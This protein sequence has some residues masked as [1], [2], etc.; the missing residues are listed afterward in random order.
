MKSI[1]QLLTTAFALVTV[2]SLG[3]QVL[4]NYGFDATSTVWNPTTV[5]TNVSA[6]D[7]TPGP[8][9]TAD[10]ID[11]TSALAVSGRSL[12]VS[13][14]NFSQTTESGAVT[15]DKYASISMTVDSGFQADLTSL[16]FSTLR[17]EVKGAGSPSAWSVYSS[18]D[19]FTAQL[20]TGTISTV[21]DDTNSF[22]L[23]STD[24]SGLT[25]LTGTTEF[26]IYFWAGDGIDTPTTRE[27][28][29]DELSVSGTVTA[30][31][32]PATMALI[33]G[34]LTLGLVLLRR[35]SR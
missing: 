11:A 22:T 29:M 28:R 15:F 12:F 10:N 26:R 27:W 24:L 1:K 2:G 32:E 5:A 8:G 3:A 7:F 31:P 17:W 35:R 34:F 14:A 13:N 20:G 25:G 19:S 16:D 33:L 4:V 9:I 23:Q 21:A 18:A 6:G 30:V